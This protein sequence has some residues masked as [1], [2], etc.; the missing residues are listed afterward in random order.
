MTVFRMVQQRS[1][2]CGA[3]L[4]LPIRFSTMEV[5]LPALLFH[6]KP[7]L[8]LG[9]KTRVTKVCHLLTP[10]HRRTDLS[11]REKRK[12]HI[13]RLPANGSFVI[14]KKHIPVK[15]Q[16]P[17]PLPTCRVRAHQAAG[18]NATSRKHPGTTA[19]RLDLPMFLVTSVHLI[20]LKISTVSRAQPVVISRSM[21]L[22]LR[23]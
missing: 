19:L 6:Q 8:K 23:T 7:L 1:R 17:K 4:Y 5:L 20:L 11:G 12:K 16:L 15:T 22:K 13:I 9:P 2:L 10:R 18:K 3:Q 14:S 21:E